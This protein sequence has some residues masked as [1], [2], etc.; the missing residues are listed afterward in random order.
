MLNF[1]PLAYLIQR[2]VLRRRF[3]T[4]HVPDQGLQLRVHADDVI[5]RHLYKYQR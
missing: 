1:R 4:A 5:G 3:L 2:W